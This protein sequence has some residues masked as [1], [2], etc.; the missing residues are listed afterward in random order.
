MQRSSC[1]ATRSPCYAAR[2]AA[3]DCP[4]PTGQCSQPWPGYCPPFV[5][6]IASS[7]R[8]PSCAGTG[9]GEA[10]LD[11]APAPSKRRPAH[12]TRAAPVGP[13]TGRR[14]LLLRLPTHPRRTD[15]AWLP[16]CGKY[17]LVDSQASRHRSCPAPR[18][19]QLA[20]IPASAGP[21]HS[22]HRL[23]LCRHAAA[24]AAVR[25]VRVRHEALLLFPDGGERPSISSLS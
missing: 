15:R 14:E 24:P 16:D 25:A 4:G 21:G 5:D 20:A 9:V 1:C 18:R 10:A 19:A 8:P 13:A 11:P 6:G 23:V 3:P 22:R 2:S 12:P 17:R 7:P